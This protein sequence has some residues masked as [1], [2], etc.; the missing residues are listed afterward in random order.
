M[1]R[2]PLDLSGLGVGDLGH[3]AGVGGVGMDDDPGEEE[4][5]G[6]GQGQ[7]CSPGQAIGGHDRNSTRA[8]PQ[9]FG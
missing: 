8:S 3:G 9:I 5:A 1:G 4:K 2:P 7:R 6:G